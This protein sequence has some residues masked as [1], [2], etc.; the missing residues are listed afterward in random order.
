MKDT[1]FIDRCI[2][3]FGSAKALAAAVSERTI[4][5]TQSAV[6]QWKRRRIAPK[7]RAV[8]AEIAD[9]KGVPLPRGFEPAAKAQPKQRAQGAR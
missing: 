9:E 4:P 5:I 1:A 7:L 2:D 3:A 8:L 6:Y